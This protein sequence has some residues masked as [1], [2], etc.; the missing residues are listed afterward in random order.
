MLLELLRLTLHSILLTLHGIR[1]IMHS[2]GLSLHSILLVMHGIRLT[3]HRILLKL[4]GKRLTLHGVL[5]A[6]HRLRNWNTNL[7]VVYHLWLIDHNRLTHRLSVGVQGWIPVKSLGVM[8]FLRVVYNLLA[9][10]KVIIIS[11]TV[12][13]LFFA[14]ASF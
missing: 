1:L 7:I 10:G 12:L 11:V 9:L 8:V 4:N 2:I 5:L 3:L 14:T 13:F 6:L